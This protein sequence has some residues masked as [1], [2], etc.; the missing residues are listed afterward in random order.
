LRTYF[1]INM[2]VRKAHE[3]LVCSGKTWR[4]LQAC[5]I[6]LKNKYNFWVF[7]RWI[8]VLSCYTSIRDLQWYF[9]VF[10]STTYIITFFVCVLSLFYLIFFSVSL[11]LVTSPL[12]RDYCIFHVLSLRWAVA[13][14]VHLSAWCD[15]CLL[16]VFAWH[17]M[18]S[19]WQ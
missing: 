5:I 19:G 3:S 13:L 7:Y 6:T 18:W 10:F 4:F 9:V 8:N 15:I 16:Q 17:R 12:V 14:S 11:I 1:K 2:A